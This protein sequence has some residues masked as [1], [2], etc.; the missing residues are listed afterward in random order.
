M[1]APPSPPEGARIPAEVYVVSLVSFLVASGFGIL[2]PSLPALGHE[3]DVGATAMSVTVSGFAAARLLANLGLARYLKNFPLRT[4]L[5]I[6]LLIQ[7]AFSIAA[8]VAP[9]YASFITLRTLSGLGSAAFTLASTALIL[10]LLPDRIRGRGM[11]IYAGASGVGTVSGP[12]LGGI[13]VGFGARVPIAVYGGLLLLAAIT[14]FLALRRVRSVHTRESEGPAVGGLR[15]LG[16]ALRSLLSDRLIVAALMASVVDGWV[17]YG[18]RNANIPMQLDVVG[19]SAAMIGFLLALASVTQLL[20]SSVSGPLSDRAGRRGPLLVGLVLGI[21]SFGS[22][23]FVGET[24][25]AVAS[26]VLIGIAGGILLTLAPTIL[27]D[28]PRGTS[29]MAMALFWVVSDLAAVIGPV[30]TGILTETIDFDYGLLAAIVLMLLAMGAAWRIGP[31]RP[32]GPPR[33]G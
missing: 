29:A 16:G 28:S 8:A 9:D 27:G 32:S 4:V 5:G 30:A 11:A 24:W 13:L 14:T 22:L 31:S 17:F 15:G 25:V 1:S 2:A 33:Q 23:A 26:H 20:G 7:S 6:G 21:V 10:I 18:V 3:F 19:Y 12:V